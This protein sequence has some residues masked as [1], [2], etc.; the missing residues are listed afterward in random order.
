MNCIIIDDENPAID[1][2]KEMIGR[3]PF[4]NLLQSFSNPFEGLE[5]IQKNTID[6]VFLDVE[7]PIINGIELMKCLRVRP[8]V[9]FT[10]INNQYAISGYDLDATDYLLK[11]LTFDRLLKATNKA[12]KI[13]RFAEFTSNKTTNHDKNPVF[14]FI[15]VKTGYNITRI[16]LDD[17]LF[18]EGLKDY[19]KIHIAGKTIVTQNSLKKFEVILPEDRFV[20]IHKSFIIPL[21]KIDAIQNNRIVIGK[22]LIPIGDNYK[23]N[24]NH[25]ILSVNV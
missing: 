12:C 2:L 4:L 18:C 24:F 14:D 17:I 22:S 15:L 8:Q 19:I 1:I 11:P 21:A 16:N 9:I 20:R 7:M 10:A 6:L 13:H 23:T 5:Y 3:L 25:K